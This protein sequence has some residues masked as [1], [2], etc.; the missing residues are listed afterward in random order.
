M[1]TPLDDA[2]LQKSDVFPRFSLQ[3][4]QG[5]Q[6]DF[7]DRMD[8]LINP[9]PLDPHVRLTSLLD[10]LEEAAR[11][12]V[13]AVDNGEQYVRENPGRPMA[14]PQGHDIFET[15]GPWEDFAT[16]SRDMRL[17]IAIDSVLGAAGAGREARP[18]ASS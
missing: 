14:M 3:Q 13:L 1:L 9:A 16:P 4:Y 5:T 17:L 2:E 15:Q 12:R 8:R 18:T 11:R 10:A 7:Y 6:D